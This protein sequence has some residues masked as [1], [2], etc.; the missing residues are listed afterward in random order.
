VRAILTRDPL[1]LMLYTEAKQMTASSRTSW[2]ARRSPVSPLNLGGYL[3]AFLAVCLYNYRKL[4]ASLKGAKL[5]QPERQKDDEVVSSHL[6]V[7]HVV[8][9]KS[10][11]RGDDSLAARTA[12]T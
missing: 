3:I 5:A 10:D 8:P 2:Y 1:L 9:C 6:T 4:T 11:A 12:L 7:C